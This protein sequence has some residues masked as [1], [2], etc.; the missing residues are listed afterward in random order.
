[1]LTY[2]EFASDPRGLTY[3]LYALES[4]NVTMETKHSIHSN[5]AAGAASMFK[6]YHS[7]Y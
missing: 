7:Q 4:Q 2:P 5:A 6:P 3:T 1:M